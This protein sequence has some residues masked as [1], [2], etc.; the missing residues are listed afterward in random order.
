MIKKAR[1]NQLKSF[2]K[3]PHNVIL[4][5]LVVV[6][7]Y[8]TLIPLIT[9]VVDTFTVHSSEVRAIKLPMG[10][11]TLYHWKIGRASCRERV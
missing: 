5:V 4:V 11:F 3:K 8:L 10:S 2:F 6:L 9:I 1:V 7:G